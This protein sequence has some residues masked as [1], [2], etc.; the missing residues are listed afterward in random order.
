[1]FVARRADESDW[2]FVVI[3]T[4][5]EGRH[6][7]R[8]P[9]RSSAELTRFMVSAQAH[10]SVALCQPVPRCPQHDHALRPFSAANEAG[11]ECPGGEWRCRVGDYEEQAWPLDLEWGMAAALCARLDRRGLDGWAR[12]SVEDRDGEQIAHVGLRASD[13]ELERAIRAAAEPLAVRFVV[14]DWPIPRRV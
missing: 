9:G 3:Q 2:G 13:A 1:M 5:E 10:V 12:V 7:V 8:M 4:G 14:A 6:R 11:W